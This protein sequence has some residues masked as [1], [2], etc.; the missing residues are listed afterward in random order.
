MQQTATRNA[1]GEKTLLAALLLSAPGPL[2]TG[3][4]AVTSGSSTQIA[5]L[6]RRTSEL[7]ATFASWLIYRKLQH[8]EPTDDEKVRLERQAALWV[9]GSMLLSGAMLLLI[10]IVRLS[11]YQPSGKGIMGLVIAFLGL[12]TNSWF[13]FRYRGMVR[14]QYDGVLDVQKKLYQAKA[15]VDLC[16]VLALLAVTIAPAHPA[17]RYIDILGSLVVAGYLLYKGLATLKGARD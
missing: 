14:Q 5:D 6:L 13:F 10:A 12:V 16:V 4:A 11:S 8:R 9:G 15:S 3:I 7:V 2:V 17:T 1:K